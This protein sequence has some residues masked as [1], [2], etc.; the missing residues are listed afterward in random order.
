MSA[1]RTDTNE[2]AQ[3]WLWGRFS[4]LGLSVALIAGLIDQAN[5]WWML[6]IYNIADRGRV[7]A[8]P[9]LDLV[10]VL[11]RGISY[12]LFTLNSQQGQYL[13][14]G[15]AFLVAAV[16]VVLLARGTETR[17]AAIGYGLILGGAVA[18]AIDR[19]HLGGVADFYSPHAFGYYW[20]VFNIADVAIVFGVVA[21]LCDMLI[22][23]RNDASNSP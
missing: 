6:N 2:A 15:F 18:N 13:L 22:P 11:N 12:S 9:F 8:L 10:F 14:S 20:Y 3:P 16:L 7:D 5:K 17:P 19:L 23:N 1:E 21:L 4:A